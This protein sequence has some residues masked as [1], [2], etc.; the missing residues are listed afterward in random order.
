M[1]DRILLRGGRVI[2]PG[3]NVDAV[4]DVL[5]AGGVVA[6]VAAGIEP[7]GA[8]VVDTTGCIVAPGLIDLHTHLREPGF[9]QKGTI[10]TETLAALRG[11]FTTVCA[12]P[13]TSPAPDSAP[14]VE[15]IREIIQRD[16]RVRVL[17]IGCVTRRREGKDLAELSE[18]AASGCIA[19]SDD[20][21]PVANA[22]LMRHAME[23]AAALGLPIS[24]HCDEPELSHGGS[25]NEG[26]VS[27]RLGLPGQPVAAETTAIARNIALCEMSGARL[28]IAHV[29]TAR[30]VELVAE[31]K[32][33]GLPVTCEVTPSHLFLTEESVFGAGPEPAY[34]TNA[35][36]NPPLRTEADR[37]ALVAGLNAGIIDAIATDHAPHAVEDKLREFDDAAF[38]IS[39]LETAV[40][41]VLTLVERGE[42]DLVTAIRALTLN[43]ARVFA[44]EARV[45]GV[46]RL[47][48]GL[49]RDLVVLAPG[50]RWTVDPARLASR[51]KNTP[52]AGVELTGSVRAV[53]FNGALAYEQEAAGV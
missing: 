4:L 29:T 48:P 34:D 18:L 47:E 14:T 5:V 23:L 9:E 45:P 43:P 2:D 44:I 25:M 50:D 22:S 28:H 12:M 51:G 40:A 31:A 52:L 26:R 21:N 33:R 24:E 19:L 6:R 13:N 41:S 17:Q 36:I 1:S 42:L 20:G 3:G 16:A 27:E 39:C 38:G 7:D 11:G 49:S 10:A 35:K 37:R 15:A 8:R 32:S 46:G 53:V 30:G